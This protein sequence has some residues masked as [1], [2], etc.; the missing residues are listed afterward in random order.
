MV[1]GVVEGTVSRESDAR[2]II[3]ALEQIP[4]VKK[5]SSAVNVQPLRVNIRFYFQGNSA[6]LQPKDLGYKLQQ[7][8]FFLNQHPKKHLKI[9]GYSNSSS[10]A[11][12]AINLAIARAKVVKQA[13]ID[14]GVEPTRLK[15]T[16]KQ[17]LPP[18]IDATQ[19]DWLKRCVILEP[20]DK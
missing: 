3:Q 8:K 4:G 6:K 20:I 5:V 12:D 17:N 19:P 2:T 13:L 14:K 1:E 15:T 7:V 9:I 16:S 11:K 10:Q 18:G